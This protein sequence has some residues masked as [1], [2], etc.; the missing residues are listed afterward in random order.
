MINELYSKI[1][2]LNCVIYKVI[3]LNDVKLLY[4]GRNWENTKE[5][6]V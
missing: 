1:R 4:N 3:V 2:K 5:F 6:N